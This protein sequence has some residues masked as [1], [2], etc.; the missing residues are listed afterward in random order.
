MRIYPNI[1]SFDALHKATD[2]TTQAG[3]NGRWYPARPHGF[4]S[5][6]QRC[7]A[8]WLVFTGKADALVWPGGQ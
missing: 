1:W 5:F 8:A 6:G 4:A 3:I 7:K 2:G